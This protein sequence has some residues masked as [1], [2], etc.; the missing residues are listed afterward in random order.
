MDELEERICAALSSDWWS[1][2]EI[3]EELSEPKDRVC[4]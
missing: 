3:A 4:A 2:E 1:P